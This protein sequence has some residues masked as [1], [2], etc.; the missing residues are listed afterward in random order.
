V[1]LLFVTNKKGVMK[2]IRVME[3]III[4]ALIRLMTELARKSD[5]NGFLNEER[6]KYS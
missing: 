4:E 2:D 6:T 5:Y 3:C 1:R